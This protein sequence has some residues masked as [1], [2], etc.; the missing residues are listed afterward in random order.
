MDGVVVIS[1]NLKAHENI[2]VYSNVELILGWECT[3]KSDGLAFT[4][5]WFMVI[6]FGFK[7]WFSSK[8]GCVEW[9]GVLDHLFEYNAELM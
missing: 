8:L 6:L 3:H 2:W 1:S 9:Y 4:L 5:C 7:N